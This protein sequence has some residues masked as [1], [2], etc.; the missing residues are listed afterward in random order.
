MSWLTFSPKA[1]PGEGRRCRQII[2]EVLL[3]SR[4]EGGSEAGASER[5]ANEGIGG[6]QVWLR[7][8]RDP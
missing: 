6:G 3:G 4:R 1:A 8:A 5:H 7:P 2:W